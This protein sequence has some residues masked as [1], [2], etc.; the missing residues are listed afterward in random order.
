MFRVALLAAVLLAAL[1]SAAQAHWELTADG[2]PRITTSSMVPAADFELS[3]CPADGAACVPA[4]WQSDPTR[5]GVYEPGETPVGTTFRIVHQASGLDERSP[6]W[7]GRMTAAAPPSVSG[8]ASTTNHVAPLPAAW[9]GGWGDETS[10]PYLVACPT[11]QG[12]NCLN[13]PPAYSCAVP[14]T[15]TPEQGRFVPSGSEAAAL[16]PVLAGHYLF[17]VEARGPQDRRGW[18]VPGLVLLTWNLNYRFELPKSDQWA[19]YA[20]STPVP[21]GATAIAPPV[22]PAPS[23]TLR[24]RA[25]RSKGRI[26]VGRVT[27]AAPSC[28]VAV[29]VSGGGKKAYYTTF[30]AKQGVT[31]ITAPV[32]RGKLTVRVHVD[33]KLLVSGKVTA[34]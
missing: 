32:R 23:V 25:L 22:I 34:R 14:C 20:I 5:V 11:P 29:K 33:G 9:S 13:L 3:V 26:S 27:C 7:Q 24:E 21:I 8:N 6:A 2:Q 16:P 12:T 28:K 19:Q 4:Q 10:K 31:A 18:P 17:A 1:P 15:A 30:V